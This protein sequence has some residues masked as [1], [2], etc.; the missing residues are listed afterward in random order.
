MS[1]GVI[2]SPIQAV[3]QLCFSWAA[4]Q[5]ADELVQHEHQVPTTARLKTQTGP[6]RSQSTSLP[7]AFRQPTQSTVAGTATKI[8]AS[9][10]ITAATQSPQTAH[11]GNYPVAPLAVRGNHEVRIGAVMI[12]LLKRYGITDAE[13]ADGIASYAQKHCQSSAS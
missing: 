13:I 7:R 3:S 12:K 11:Q 10:R 6:N 4:E 2:D 9:E 8:E 5:T 1:T